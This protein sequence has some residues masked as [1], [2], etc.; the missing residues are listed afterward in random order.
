MWPRGHAGSALIM[1]TPLL[2]YFIQYDIVISTI[3][4]LTIMW[5]SIIPDFDFVDK[6][7]LSYLN[8]RGF[9]HTFDFV[10][11]FSI[12]S[13]IVLFPIILYFD[14]SYPVRL[15]IITTPFYG[16]LS[17][18]IVDLLDTSGINPFYA[19]SDYSFS[20]NYNANIIEDG[21]N[22]HLNNTILAVGFLLNTTI[23]IYVDYIGL[24]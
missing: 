22:P 20:R 2:Y 23:I 18:I 16:V 9:T 8:H 12:V 21:S 5:I 7:V 6:S 4:T 13:Y 24:Y 10:V 19:F 1:N 14:I 17:H 15:Y 11:L 3:C